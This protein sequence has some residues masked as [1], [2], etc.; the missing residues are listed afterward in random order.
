MHEGPPNALRAAL[1]E[2]STN[3]DAGFLASLQSG[4]DAPWDEFFLE[5]DA[6]IRSVVSWPKW[7]FTHHV[8]QDLAQII[9]AELVRSLS[10]L[11]DHSRVAGFVK[12]ISVN[13]CIDEVRRQVRKDGSSFSL[14]VHDKDGEWKE[15]DVD[16][17][18]D[19]DP[20]RAVVLATRATA[21]H[22]LLGQLN[23]TCQKAID[24]FY[25]Q[26]M[27]YKDIAK[28]QGISIKT[29]GSRLAKCLAKLKRLI[30]RNPV[31]SEQADS[32]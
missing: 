31:L 3:I 8:Q 24:Q 6:L 26:G 29:V 18:E 11:K 27:A 21:L 12:R 16:A 1:M 5:F 15:M 30:V 14:T 23:E 2:R 22:E 20:V 28:D 32:T 19:F 7:H 4:D 17:G 10:T 25:M 13:R 9:R